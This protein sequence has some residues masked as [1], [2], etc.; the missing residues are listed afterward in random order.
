MMMAEYSIT[1]GGRATL[2]L[3]A[4]ADAPTLEI[5]DARPPAGGFVLPLDEPPAQEP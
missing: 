5:S 2:A 1:R 4:S 3:S